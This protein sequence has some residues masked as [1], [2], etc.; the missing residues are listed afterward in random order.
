M[1]LVIV[2]PLSSARY[3]AESFR[4]LRIPTIALLTSD[5][6]DIPE[7]FRITPDLFDEQILVGSRDIGDI[8]AALE[9]RSVTFVLNGRENSTAITDQIANALTPDTSNDPST[10]E[11]RTDK[12]AMTQAIAARG[13][14]HIRQR[15]LSLSGGGFRVE[16]ADLGWPAFIRPTRG[17]AS[18]GAHK[19]AS[20]DDLRDY[21][22]QP[23]IETLTDLRGSVDQD[24]RADFVLS[25]FIDATEYFVDTFSHAGAH[26]FSSI[27]RYR[28]EVIDGHPMLRYNEVETD[29]LVVGRVAE[30][31]R[32]V[33]DAIGLDNGFA[34]TELFVGP[35]GQPLLIE[36]N[37]RVSGGSGTP[38]QA[39]AMEGLLSQPD[40]LRAVAYDGVE[41]PAYSPPEHPR[42]RVLCLFHFSTSPLPDLRARLE[43]FETVRSVLLL[44][45]PGYVHPEAPTSLVDAV[46]IAIC[47]DDD[48]DHL[49]DETERILERD[50]QGWI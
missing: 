12:F 48:P 20:P 5:D 38:N 39:T 46:A 47:Q 8:L 28:K 13:L 18:L 34:H 32:G 26:Y 1:T 29:A 50:R 35:D 7:H 25:E 30:Y 37:P 3:L 16:D 23:G 9:G 24:H 14:P 27:Q 11:I 6:A 17:V 4:H 49:A 33:L 41:P 45:E 31:V 43:A 19:L 42:V 10:S 36:V 40:L 22:T 44:H 21:L 15:V 2:D